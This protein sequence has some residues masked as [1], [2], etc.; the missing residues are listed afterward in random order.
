ML[1]VRNNKFTTK[2]TRVMCEDKW[3][4]HAP[5]HFVVENVNTGEV[6]GKV[7]FQEGPVNEVGINGVNNEDLLLMVVTRLTGF[8]NSE[9][10]C[11]ENQEAIV[12]IMEAVDSLRK[13]T[14]KR[15][16]KGVEGTSRV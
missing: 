6:V 7:D 14:M 11:N 2:Y 1:Q 9:Y 4:Y 13:R 8:Q 5:H 3:N 12:S 16:A 10:R 15:E